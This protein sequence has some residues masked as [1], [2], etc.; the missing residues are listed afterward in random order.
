MSKLVLPESERKQDQGAE[1]RQ[2]SGEFVTEASF[3]FIF[4]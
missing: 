1:Q 2:T 3:F 4:L